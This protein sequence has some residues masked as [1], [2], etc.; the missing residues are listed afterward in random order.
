MVGVGDNMSM[1]DDVKKAS[2]HNAM[3]LGTS[4]AITLSWLSSTFAGIELPQEVAIALTGVI[5][6]VFNNF[7]TIGENK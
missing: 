5:L 3:G 4:V 6:M 2:K 1:K 7:N